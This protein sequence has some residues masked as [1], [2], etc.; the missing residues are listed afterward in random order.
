MLI[1]KID[2]KIN[3][4]NFNQVVT[5][6]NRIVLTD[7]GRKLDYYYLALKYKFNNKHRD[8][9]TYTVSREGIIYEHYD[10]KYYSDFF[11]DDNFNKTA[12]T[13][14]LENMG[15]LYINDNNQNY[16][17]ILNEKYESKLKIHSQSWRRFDYFEAYPTK[18]QNST[19]EL[20][21]FL[22]TEFKI[23]NDTIGNNVYSEYALNYNGIICTSNFNQCCLDLNPS[24]NFRKLIT[25][26]SN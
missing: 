16:Y 12:I 5:D 8:Y 25:V 21:N 1:N 24:Y 2:R 20:C 10:P 3:N 14:N 13:I 9:P 22:C 17:N 18:Q 15:G 23:M 26:I 6:K 4:N 19:N 11:S 7:S